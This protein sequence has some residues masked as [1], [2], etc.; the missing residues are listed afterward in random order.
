MSMHFD[1]YEEARFRKSTEVMS[2]NPGITLNRRKCCKCGEYR[3]HTGGKIV[4]GTSRHN[5]G[6]F[7]C[8]NCV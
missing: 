2:K 3:E 5:P 4:R 8:A 6:T 1:P 7:T